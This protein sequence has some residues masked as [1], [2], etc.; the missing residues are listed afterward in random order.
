MDLAEA[1]AKYYFDNIANQNDI[2]SNVGYNINVGE[3]GDSTADI[4]IDGYGDKVDVV[5]FRVLELL[6]KIKDVVGTSTT[7]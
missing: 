2:G 4:R 1:S 6:K 7:E 3:F 5:F